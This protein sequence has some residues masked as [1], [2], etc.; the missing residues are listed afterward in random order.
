MIPFVDIRLDH[1]FWSIFRSIFWSN[2]WRILSSNK[3]LLTPKVLILQLRFQQCLALGIG[4]RA[5]LSIPLL[6]LPCTNII[7]FRWMLCFHLRN[8]LWFLVNHILH[9][10]S[11]RSIPGRVQYYYL[12]YNYRSWICWF[13]KSWMVELLLVERDN[14][15]LIHIL[16]NSNKLSI[17]D[18]ISP[19]KR[20]FDFETRC[21][22]WGL[23]LT[24]IK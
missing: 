12:M 14:F 18:Y 8:S 5:F 20:L 4:H 15:L 17:P 24:R 3:R 1:L 2:L 16:S 13:D 6:F 19:Q 23:T 22:N 21:Y 9:S 10:P 7:V 11:I